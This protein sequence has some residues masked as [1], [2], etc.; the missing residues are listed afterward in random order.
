MSLRHLKITVLILGTIKK[1]NDEKENLASCAKIL[2]K[3]LTTQT[4]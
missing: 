1:L 4:M 2:Q 3:I